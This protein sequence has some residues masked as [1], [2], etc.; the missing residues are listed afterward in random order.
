MENPISII[1]VWAL[2]GG[3]VAAYVIFRLITDR[4]TDAKRH[5]LYP[6]VSNATDGMFPEKGDAIGRVG[7]ILMLFGMFGFLSIL[8]IESTGRA[9][10]GYLVNGVGVF[11]VSGVLLLGLSKL[12]KRRSR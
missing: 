9:L 6:L 11:L 12:R 2:L 10:A 5:I 8:Y 7:Y 4:R 3:V 1:V